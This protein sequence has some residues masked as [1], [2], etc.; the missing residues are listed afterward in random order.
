MLQLLK[1]IDS[2]LSKWTEKIRR[3]LKTIDHI[4]KSYL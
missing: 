2:Y 3:L 4:S 1:C